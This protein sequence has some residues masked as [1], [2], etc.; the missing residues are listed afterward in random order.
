MIARRPFSFKG[1]VNDGSGWR[2]F[3]GIV[4]AGWKL[5]VS[6][7]LGVALQTKRL[8]YQT[9]ENKKAYIVNTGGSWFEVRYGNKV[10][11][12]QGKAKAEA[13]RDEINNS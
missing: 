5:K 13:L 3:N 12:V 4:Q 6:K 10:D 9:K 7:N 11:K 8:V 1:E 2:S